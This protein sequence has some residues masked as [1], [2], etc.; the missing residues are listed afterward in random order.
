ME[1]SLI[2]RSQRQGINSKIGK[3]KKLFILAKGVK[4]KKGLKTRATNTLYVS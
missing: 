4:A 1:A 2:G 3:C